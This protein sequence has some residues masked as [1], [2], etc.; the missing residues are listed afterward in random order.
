MA[1]IELLDETM[2]DGQQSLWGMRMQAGMALPVAPMIDRSGYRV[3][4]L[5]G[6][7]SVIERR[8]LPED[9]PRQRKPDI[10]LA[11]EKLDWKPKVPLQEG[12]RRT[13]E[14]FDDMLRSNRIDRFRLSRSA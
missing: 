10:R 13:I 11:Q 12:L 14:Y 9:D 1:H 3:I 4:D 6:S 2:R 5:T 7:S 8:P